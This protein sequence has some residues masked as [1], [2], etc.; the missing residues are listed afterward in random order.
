[1]VQVDVIILSWNRVDDTIAAIASTAEQEGV[2][3]RI[4]IVDQASEPD[5]LARLERFLQRVPCAAL[6]KLPRNVGVAEGRNIASAMGQAPFIVAL[7]SD[8]VFADR[9]MLARAV[10]HLEANPQLCAIGFRILN[11]FTG[12]NDDTA[13]DYP[14]SFLPD[15]AFAT[16]RFMGGGHALHR[17]TF[18]AVGAYD[19]RL[20]FCGEEVDLCY[21]MLNTGKRIAYLPTVTILHKVSPEQRVFW[22]KGRFFYTVRN[23]LYSLYK[24]GMPWPR[25]LLATGAFLVGGLRNR[26]PIEALRGIVASTRMCRDFNSSSEDKSVYRLSE[27]T[28]EYI[29]Q[30]EPSRSQSVLAKIRRQF[31]A[32]PNHS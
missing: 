6:K 3:K 20:F 26:I 8:A 22:G 7:D 1:M 2:E 23:T 30:C 4:L 13:W 29:L 18:E 32:L 11:Y 17:A 19:H 27:S 21:R 12:S 15:Q 25:R 5:N 31:V 24:F 14:A 9:H 28:W 16:T 10:E